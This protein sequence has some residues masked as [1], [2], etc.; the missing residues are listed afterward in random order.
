MKNPYLTFP[1]EAFSASGGKKWVLFPRKKVH[2]RAA[3]VS[4][5]IPG[6][7]PSAQPLAAVSQGTCPISHSP[8]TLSFRPGALRGA[9]SQCHAQ[10]HSAQGRRTRGHQGLCSGHFLKER[11]APS[12]REVSGR[13][14]ASASH[15][16][17][18]VPLRSAACSLHPSGMGTARWHSK[19]T[20]ESKKASPP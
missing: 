1:M 2:G 13:A 17:H 15:S 10:I 6:R 5:W 20:K 18:R 12:L 19:V 9:C 3:G 7:T 4:L 14:G 16:A 11:S 8:R